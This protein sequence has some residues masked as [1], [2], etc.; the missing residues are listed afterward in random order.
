MGEETSYYIGYA[1]MDVSDYF[2]IDMDPKLCK[3]S[4]KCNQQEQLAEFSSPAANERFFGHSLYEVVSKVA[5]DTEVQ[6]EAARLSAIS[7]AIVVKADPTPL[8]N[9]RDSNHT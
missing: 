9:V 2:D 8:P 6:R 5:H 4:T 7:E 3:L 1:P